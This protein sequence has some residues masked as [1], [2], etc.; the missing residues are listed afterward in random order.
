M[1]DYIQLKKTIDDFKIGKV[2]NLSDVVENWDKFTDG[3]KRQ[4]GIKFHEYAKLNL[5]MKLDIP[6]REGQIQ[7]YIKK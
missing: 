3:D 7:K 1:L 4:A 2:F 6:P 5:T